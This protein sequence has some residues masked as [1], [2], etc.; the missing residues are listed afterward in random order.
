MIE[1]VLNNRL[2]KK[3][4]VKCNKDDTIGDL[5]KLVVT[6]NRADK[7]FIQKWYNNYKDHITF[8]DHEIHDGMGLK[9]YYN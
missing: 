6:Q 2:G 9:L 1:M 7:I 4:K 5:K 8:K 3:V